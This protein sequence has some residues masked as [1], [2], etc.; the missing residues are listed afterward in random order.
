MRQ[1]AAA[2]VGASF[3]FLQIPS[4]TAATEKVVYSFCSQ[5]S[6]ADGEAPDAGVLR[7]GSALYVPTS[8]G[9]TNDWGTLVDINRKT[10][11]ATVLYSFENYF[12]D[13]EDPEAALL[14]MGGR[15]YGTTAAGGAG[16]NE[17][18]A[19]TV[20]TL[21]LKNGKVK[22]SYSFCIQSDC[23]DGASP[24]AAL[25]EMNG[26]S[27]GT[28]RFG[29]GNDN[30]CYG[31]FRGCGTVFSFD[32]STGAEKVVHAFCASGSCAEG[33]L[34]IGGL[35]GVNGILYGTTLYGGSG[36]GCDDMG[37][38]CGTVFSLDPSSGA[39]TVLHVF[40]GESADG[41]APMAG[42]VN[43]NG[44]LYGTT[45]YGGSTSIGCGTWDGCGTVFSIDPTSGAER[46]VHAF[47]DNGRDGENPVAALIDVNGTLYG[48]T[49]DGGV[50]GYGTVFAVD[51]AT[52]TEKVLYSFCSQ[53]KCIDG[54]Y[55]Y[56]GLIE[57]DGKLY[58]TTQAGGSANY[59]TVFSI[60]P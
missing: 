8:S 27:Y 40:A 2:L 41:G 44:T 30:G 52:G 32:A 22:L 14:K 48:T 47:K 35:T 26:V 42:L 10:G 31:L 46:V 25:L 3:I 54:A 6:C 15:L 50:Y 51:P 59:G 12:D 55:P 1:L 57:V 29:G 49:E 37:R 9:G 7:V 23:T 36:N 24:T 28:T 53:Q 5:A 13:A 20:Y 18:G 58:G 21:N 17:N 56:A 34:P 33:S 11:L 43:V 60:K 19:G 4:G 39:E 16:N 38:G 45:E